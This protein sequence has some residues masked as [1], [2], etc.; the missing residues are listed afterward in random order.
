MKKKPNKYE[1]P[2]LYELNKKI[3]QGIDQC[4]A[5]SSA[6]VDCFSGITAAKTCESGSG[7]N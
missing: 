6:E 2:D 7:T 3:S 1:K 5:G 4:E